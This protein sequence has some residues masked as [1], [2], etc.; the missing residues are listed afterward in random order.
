VRHIDVD[1]FLH[2]ASYSPNSYK[3]AKTIHNVVFSSPLHS[4]GISLEGETHSMFV[5]KKLDG[6]SRM[7]D[8]GVYTINMPMTNCPLPSMHQN[9]DPLCIPLSIPQPNIGDTNQNTSYEETPTNATPSRSPHVPTIPLG[10][11][12][13]FRVPMVE[14]YVPPYH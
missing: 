2:V 11:G 12:T 3:F 1:L 8:K 5:K 13:Q 10:M 7:L 4:G 9:M 6:N 14:S